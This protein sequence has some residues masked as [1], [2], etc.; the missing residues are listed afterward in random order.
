MNPKKNVDLKLIIIGALGV[1]KTSLLHQYVHKTFYEDYQTTLGASIL[2][3][4]I[5]L[6]GVTLKLQIW[7]TGG[8]ER[9]RSMVSTFYK[10]SDGCLLAFDVTDSD[11]FEALDT[12]RG[13]VLAKI[14]PMEETYPMVVLGN[15]ID[16]ND[17]QVSQEVAQHWCKEKGITYFEVSAKNDINVVQAFEMLASQALSRYQSNFEN[18]LT[19]SIKLAPEDKPQ[20]A[21][22]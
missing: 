5:I 15:K 18:Y 22:C 7:D 9:F 12:W 10:G 4:R 21:C 6:D 8:Q 2:S 3:K 14:V 11:S 20:T 17:R 13:D 19:G 1:G 16:L